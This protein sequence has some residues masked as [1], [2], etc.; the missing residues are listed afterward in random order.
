MST[1]LKTKL[2]EENLKLWKVRKFTGI[3]ESSISLISNGKTNM[4]LG[5]LKK[6][7][8]ML[9]CTPNDIIDWSMDFIPKTKK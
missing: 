1:K 9:K 3:M 4:M 6:F 2:K 8:R 7:C 5:T